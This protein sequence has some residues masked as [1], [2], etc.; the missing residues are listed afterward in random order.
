MTPNFPPAFQ[1]SP[2]PTETLS[3]W[4][5][6]VAMMISSPMSTETSSALTALGDQLAANGWFEA[7]HSWYVSNY[8]ASN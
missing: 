2:V 1:T 4:A 5:E 8:V 3:Q 6:T 7:A